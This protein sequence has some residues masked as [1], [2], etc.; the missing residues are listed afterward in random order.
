MHRI[1][2][3]EDDADMRE[4]LQFVLQEANFEVV[5]A[6]DA[7]TARECL[8][9]QSPAMI[10]LDW[11]LPDMSGL[12]MACQIKRNMGTCNPLLW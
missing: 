4:M 10:L 6:Q 3:V 9:R 5:E 8:K 1:L 2:I 11:L 12:E 7:A